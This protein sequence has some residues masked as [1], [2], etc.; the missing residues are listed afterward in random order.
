MFKILWDNILKLFGKKQINDRQ[1][2]D[3][4]RYS[5]AYQNTNGIN[6]TSIFSN[7]LANYSVN[8]CTVDID[9]DDKRSE[10]LKKTTKRLKKKLKKI[11]SRGIGTGGSLAV[12]YVA[13]NKIYFDIV[14]QNRLSINKIYGE[15]ITDCTILAEVIIRNNNRYCRWADYTLENGNLFIRYRA[16]LENEPIPLQTIPEW[17]TIED[18]NITNVDRM[19]FM[20][21]KCPIDNRKES[22]NYG[23]PITYGCDKEIKNIKETLDQILREYDLKQVFVGADRTMFKGEDALPLNGLYKKIDSGEDS[24][25]EVFDPAFRDTSLY[26][27]LEKQCALLE[28]QV[29][30]SRGILTDPLSTYQ[31]VDETRRALYDTFSIVDDIRDSLSDGIDDFIY[32]CDVLAN[33]YNLTP[34]GKYDIVIDWDYSMI[35][36]S[37]TQWNQLIQGKNNGAIEEVEI[38][39][40]IKPEETLEEAQEVIKRIKENNPSTKDLLGE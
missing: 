5:H 1:T 29:G 40:Y 10:L 36:D 28:K 16:T 14:S 38:R 35:E 9:G 32:A 7:R 11:V 33:Y 34:Q 20:Y 6:F 30:T 13:N 19:P 21:F 17:A 8:D 26:N 24:F 23:V 31:N 39:Q 15:D 2:D 18:I 4:N 22:D 12:P 37:Q 25:W 27:K 3:N